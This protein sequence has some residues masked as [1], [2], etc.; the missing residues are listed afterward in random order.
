MEVYMS[1]NTIKVVSQQWSNWIWNS[2][3]VSS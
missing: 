1:T 2:A 3:T